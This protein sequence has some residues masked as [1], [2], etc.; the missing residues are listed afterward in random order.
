LEAASYG[1]CSAIQLSLVN[2]IVCA[3]C[4]MRHTNEYNRRLA[5]SQKAP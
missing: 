5:Q 3:R 1:S 2:A 4:L